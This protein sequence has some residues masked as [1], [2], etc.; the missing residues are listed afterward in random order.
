MCANAMYDRAASVHRWPAKHITHATYHLTIGQT[1]RLDLD[2]LHRAVERDV[3]THFHS[4][5]EIWVAR[6]TVLVTLAQRGRLRS[7]LTLN[8]SG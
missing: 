4:T 3:E 6:Q 2:R 8:V 7:N 5:R 1:V